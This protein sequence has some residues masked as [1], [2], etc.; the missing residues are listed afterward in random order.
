MRIF[1]L[2]ESDLFDLVGDLF[3]LE[4]FHGPTLAFKDVGLQFLA[5]LL[6]Y[7]LGKKN[8]TATGKPSASELPLA[9]L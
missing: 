7:F 3:V 5:E 4:T 1:N 6:N 2:N 9:C 8:K